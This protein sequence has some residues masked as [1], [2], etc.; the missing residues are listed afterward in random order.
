MGSLQKIVTPLHVLTK[1]NYLGRM[2]DDKVY[3]MDIAKKYENDYWD[4]D[5]RFGYGGYK[6]IPDRWK[7]VAESLINTYQL[8]GNS[9]ILDIGCGKGFL[10]HEIKLILPKIKILG[11]EKF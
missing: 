5:R 4:G 3:C 9:S 8:D 11:S 1:R 10:L 6:Y 2:N 7:T